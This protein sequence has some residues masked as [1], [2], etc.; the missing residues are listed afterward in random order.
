[1]PDAYIRSPSKGTGSLTRIQIM[2]VRLHLIPLCSD[3]LILLDYQQ[4]LSLKIGGCAEEWSL[5]ETNEDAPCSV[6]AEGY[7]YLYARFTKHCDEK[8]LINVDAGGAAM[9]ISRLIIENG[10]MVIREVLNLKNFMIDDPDI[11][12][13]CL[14]CWV[15]KEKEE[16]ARRNFLRSGYELQGCQ[17]FTPRNPDFAPLN[18]DLRRE[19][20]QIHSLPDFANP[21]I[22][23]Q[24]ILSGRRCA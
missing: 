4:V 5:I 8:I 16:A 15:E 24:Q 10:D 6:D 13:A 18:P 22:Q 14:S 3:P 11:N 1:M 23:M 20:Y 19:G 7:G 21:R 17:Y 9:M 2:L 12:I